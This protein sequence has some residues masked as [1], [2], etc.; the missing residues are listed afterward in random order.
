MMRV[1]TAVSLTRGSTRSAR[2]SRSAVRVSGL[3]PVPRSVEPLLSLRMVR[4]SGS[5]RPS[6]EVIP[7]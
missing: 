5:T 3:S 7:R 1:V 4:P 2:A 6:G